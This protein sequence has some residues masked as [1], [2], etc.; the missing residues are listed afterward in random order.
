[1][2][3]IYTALPFI[4]D[5]LKSSLDR[6]QGN[7]GSENKTIMKSNDWTIGIN[8]LAAAVQLYFDKLQRNVYLKR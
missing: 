3:G 1:M 6:G 8:K 7:R 2:W 4:E 5:D